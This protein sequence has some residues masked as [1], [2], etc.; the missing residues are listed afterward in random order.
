MSLAACSSSGSSTPSTTS[1]AFAS[2]TT[3]RPDDG[4]LELGV[5][6]P[7]GGSEAELGTSVRDGVDLAVAEI[8]K[9][10]GV[11]G[12]PV[13]A[14]VRDEGENPATA[15]LAMQDLVQMGVDAIIGPTSSLDA[16]GVLKT[17]VNAG[18]LTCSPTASAMS[19]DAFPD[20]GL[21]V[22]TV[23][24]DSLEAVAMAR[25]VEQ[26]GSSQAA[27]VYLDDAYG[28]P[29]AQAVQR[30]LQADGTTV[31]MSMGVDGSEASIKKTVATLADHHPDV[32]VV[33]ADSSTGPSIINAIDSA[34]VVDKPTYVVN[35]AQR[36]PSAG[37]ATFSGSLAQRIE[38]V[39][40]LA[41]SSDTTFVRALQ[42][43][44]ATTTGLYAANAYDCVNV[45]ALS[46]QA[47]H[48]SVART[49]SASVQAVTT[50]GT[51]C[52]QFSDCATELA[53]G[54][55]IDYN[56]PS[57]TLAIGS[58][59]DVTNAVFDRFGFNDAGRDVSQGTITI[60]SG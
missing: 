56:G 2:T 33:V 1:T 41:Y 8:N 9:A 11:N 57:E 45:I 14:V 38:G 12:Q 16:L 29:F 30:G 6:A 43:V 21:F 22:R 13:R 27:V 19:L 25:L 17:A 7:R 24:S 37:S 55:N 54:H 3:A 60:G 44:D 15:A 48:S 34:I 42:G 50:N 46:A 23:P 58:D 35:D 5:I 47:T 10:G 53:A 49:I 52:E 28:R 4:R 39:S 20:N 26:S 18:V 31:S 36:R 40:P 51:A 59:G 32:V